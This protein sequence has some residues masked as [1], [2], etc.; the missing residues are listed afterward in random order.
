MCNNNEQYDY[1]KHPWIGRFNSWLLAKYE[2][3]I[4]QETGPM[5]LKWMKHLQGTVVEIGPGNGINFC[6]YPAGVKVFAIEPNPSMYG[7]LRLSAKTAEADIELKENFLEYMNLETSSID[8][9]VCTMVLCSVTNPEA[10]LKE[11]L[12]ILKPNGKYIYVEHVAAPKGSMKRK[13]QNLLFRTWKCLFEG[14]ETNR[15]TGALLQSAGFSQVDMNRFDST[16][17]P[18][19][20]S[21]NIVGVAIK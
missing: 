8:A 15:N 14:C 10:T 11:V 7:R 21:P 9:V 18:W 19:L 3:K 1:N 5:K 17:M 20:I 6:Y 2:D 13:A 16:A 12:R 4:R